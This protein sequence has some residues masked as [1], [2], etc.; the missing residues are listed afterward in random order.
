MAPSKT[1]PASIIPSMTPAVN[2]PR[3][4]PPSMTKPRFTGIFLSLRKSVSYPITIG[5]ICKG[6]PFSI[7]V[8]MGIIF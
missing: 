8:Q 2:R 7:L 1:I 3:M 6:G 4:A 5:G